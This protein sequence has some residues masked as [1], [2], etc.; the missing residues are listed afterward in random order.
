[1]L[2]QHAPASKVPD[3]GSPRTEPLGAKDDVVPGQRHDEEER[4]A[5]D[6]LAGDRRSPV[7]QRRYMM[8]TLL[9]TSDCPS[10]CGWKAVVMCNLLPTKRISSCQNVDV[11]IRVKSLTTGRVCTGT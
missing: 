9:A 7:R 1:M 10:D 8:M 11:K 5:D 3:D 2:E 6:A 4:V